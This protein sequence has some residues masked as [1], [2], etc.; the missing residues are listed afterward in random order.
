MGLDELKLDSI[1]V[2]PQVVAEIMNL[3]EDT[4]ISFSQLDKLLKADQSIATIILKVAN[5][6]LYARGGNIKTLQIAI[7]ILGFKMVRSLVVLASTKSLF[8]SGKYKKFREYVWRHSIVTAIVSKSLTREL[9]MKPLQ[10]EAFVGGLLHDIGKVVLNN[11]DRQKFIESMY[12]GLENKVTFEEAETK[13]LGFNHI[14]AGEKAVR[15][16]KLPEIFARVIVEHETGT[17]EDPDSEDSKLVN[18]V[19]YANYIAKLVGHG[20]YVEE[21]EAPVGEK[22]RERLRLPDKVHKYFTEEFGSTLEED[23]FFKLCVNLI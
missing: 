23:E 9:G 14:A 8:G 19:A 6:P 13:V 7:S 17:D 11:Y 22:L 16:W 20:H 12:Y 5:S 21:I 3:E 10:E 15:E 4:D 2:M 18:I 1:P